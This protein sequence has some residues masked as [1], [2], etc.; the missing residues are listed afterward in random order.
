M[1]ELLP[2]LPL[3]PRYYPTEQVSEANLRFLAAEIVREKIIELTSEEL[4]YASAV[5]ITSFR[6]KEDIT[7]IE[8]CIYVERG[9]QK[10]IVIGRG[11][12]HD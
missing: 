7:I 11:R 2:L 1:A 8:A 9:S 5:E 3:G 10:G 12:S 6:E 4:P